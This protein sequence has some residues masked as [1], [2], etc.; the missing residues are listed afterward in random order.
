MHQNVVLFYTM[1]YNNYVMV[2]YNYVVIV[3]YYTIHEQSS[4]YYMMLE[5]MS[6]DNYK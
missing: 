1:V 6:H 2:W 5:G 3:S 4:S